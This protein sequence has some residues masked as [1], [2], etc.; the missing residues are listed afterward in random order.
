MSSRFFELS[1]RPIF[2]QFGEIKCKILYTLLRKSL[3]H[4]SNYHY[5]YSF[6]LL[7]QS[8]I[9]RIIEMF[10]HDRGHFYSPFISA[11]FC[12]LYILS[13]CYHVYK[14]LKF[15]SSWYTIFL[16]LSFSFYIQYFFIKDYT[17]WYS[18]SYTCFILSPHFLW[19]AFSIILVSTF[20]SIF[21][22][23][24]TNYIYFKNFFLTIF[25]SH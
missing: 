6:Y 23:S 2:V 9:E 19:Y 15:L 16:Y 13:V 17:F 8:G 25:I 4:C 10:H 14:H 7:I 20:I 3:S 24:F 5:L 18:C 11:N 22:N 21:Q 12:F 1:V